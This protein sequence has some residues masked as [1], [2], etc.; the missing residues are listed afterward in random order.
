MRSNYIAARSAAYNAQN[1]RVS[2][3]AREAFIAT[4]TGS[5]LGFRFVLQDARRFIVCGE[6][7]QHRDEHHMSPGLGFRFLFL[8]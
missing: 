2:V 5:A 4:S 1:I 7:V 8:A 3:A 6:Q